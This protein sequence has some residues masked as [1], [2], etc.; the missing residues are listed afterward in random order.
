M[1]SQVS[2]SM[3]FLTSSLVP[4]EPTGLL[5]LVN[6]LQK[7]VNKSVINNLKRLC[8]GD[9]TT[10]SKFKRKKNIKLQTGPLYL[11]F[12]LTDKMFDSLAVGSYQSNNLGY[13]EKEETTHFTGFNFNVLAGSQF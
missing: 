6:G 1:F 8:E 2:P 5:L 12:H 3:H 11:I 4:T 10:Y 7:Q 13:N 9:L